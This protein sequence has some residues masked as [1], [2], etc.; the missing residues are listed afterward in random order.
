M[1]TAHEAATFLREHGFKKSEVGIV[2]GTGLG[3]GFV[4]AMNTKASI[5][6]R[7]IPNFPYATVQSHRGQLIYGELSGKNIVVMQGRVHYYEGYRMD[8]VTFPVQ[9]MHELGVTKLFVTNAA[10]NLNL[11]W[12]RSDI[13][14]ITDHINYLPVNP[15]RGIKMSEKN[16]REL[17]SLYS[18]ALCKIARQ[19]ARKQKLPLREGVY[20]A[21]P[22][23]S[24]ETRSEYRYFKFIGGDA[25][26]MST[27][28]E[29]LMAR[30]LG[31][32]VCGFSILTNDCDPDNL[33]AVD[34]NHIIDAA[35]KAE[36]RL[37][38]LL[39]ELIAT[40]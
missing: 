20:V 11:K 31:I 1:Q 14:L 30:A 6:Y 26:G 9:V 2:L 24:L 18:Q 36:K 4:S 13:M 25:V 16:I 15:F 32:E 3:E 19:L 27:V 12:H 22:G 39:K 8:Q 33:S 40:L 35:A 21:V 5:H 29:V 23:P 38:H 37:S 34:L 28:P 7:N 17:S 10:G